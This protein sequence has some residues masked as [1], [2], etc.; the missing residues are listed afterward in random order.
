MKRVHKSILVSH[1]AQQMRELVED[2]ERY[3]RFLPWCSDAKVLAREEG[4]TRASIQIR[5]HGLNS[6]F[7]TENRRRGEDHIEMNLVEGPF[8]VLHG[9]W[10]FD[11]LAEHACR[12]DFNLQYEFSSKMLA[13]IAG[14]VFHKISDALVDAFVRRA[15]SV[16]GASA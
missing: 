8:R 1:S 7:T 11:A 4:V 10:H 14:P 3:P 12:V 9:L 15:E 16:Y 13:V 5:Y 6:A 2:V